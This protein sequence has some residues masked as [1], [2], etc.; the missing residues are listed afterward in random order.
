MRYCVKREFQWQSHGQFHTHKDY[1][2]G[3]H[4]PVIGDGP[5]CGPNPDAVTWTPDAGL[6]SSWHTE[7][8]AQAA[9]R[10][11]RD[12]KARVVEL[13]PE[14]RG[15]CESQDERDARF[16]SAGYAQAVADVAAR[17]EAA[18][19]RAAELETLKD[20]IL[21][22]RHMSARECTCMELPCVCHWQETIGA[23][24]AKLADAKASDAESLRLYRSASE[25]AEAGDAM[26]RELAA[27]L[28]AAER[29]LDEALHWEDVA[30]EWSE[31]IKDC[32]PTVNGS[33]RTYSVAMKMVGHR[34]SKGQLVALV[35]WS[36]LRAEAAEKRAAEAEVLAT[37]RRLS[38]ETLRE[39]LALERAASADAA[40]LRAR[41]AELE[42]ACGALDA[43]ATRRLADNE[44]LREALQRL[45]DQN[46][47]GLTVD[48][49]NA[50]LTATDPANKEPRG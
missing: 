14:R 43:T 7:D 50:T 32:H 10:L 46:Y 42:A 13:E 3:V 16:R 29:E 34:H 44:R 6:A 17:A 24:A 22:E 47:V 4:Y 19:K 9:A 25:R 11:T 5:Y 12:T 20:N 28:A 38:I 39:S 27:K 15:E 30:D 33:H 36:L 18:E 26:V 21:E 49:I 8:A 23:M 37:E 41:V 35:N 48:F 1:L 45:R 31:R 40:T 2:V